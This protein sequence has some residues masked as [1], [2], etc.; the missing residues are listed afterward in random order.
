[1]GKR[2]L[3]WSQAAL[4]D[5]IGIFE[6]YNTRNDSSVY[7]AKLLRDFRKTM[8]LVVNNPCLGLKTEDD[9]IRYIIV[10]NYALFYQ[11]SAKSIDVLVVWD[12]KQDPGKLENK[13]K[14]SKTF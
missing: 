5:M 2:K 9:N 12:C 3:I 11:L 1:M 8:H 4:N 10:G 14:R 6:F 7:S 13:I